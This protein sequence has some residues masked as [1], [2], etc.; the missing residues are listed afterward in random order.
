MK[1][2]SVT[3][4]PCQVERERFGVDHAVIGSWLGEIWSL[5]G[6]VCEAIRYYRDP[7]KAN[8]NPYTDT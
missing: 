1:E 2:D 3:L 5:P 7:D 8:E 4:P 6:Q